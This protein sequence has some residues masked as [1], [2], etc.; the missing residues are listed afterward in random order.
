MPWRTSPWP[1]RQWPARHRVRPS[2]ERHAI[3]PL[4][5]NGG[6]PTLKN[7][8]NGNYPLYKSLAFVYRKE[9]LPAGA[10]LFIDYVRSKEGEK[11]MKASGYLPEK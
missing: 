10:K 1:G 7:L 11:I 6:A 3:K 8:H 5:V 2:S 9:T 4:R